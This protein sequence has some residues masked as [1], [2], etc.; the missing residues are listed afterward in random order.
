MIQRFNDDV[1][2]DDDGD[3]DDD[4]DD[5]DDNGSYDTHLVTAD[6]EK[7]KTIP[8]TNPLHYFTTERQTHYEETI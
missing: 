4:D 7:Y 6:V 3:D 1:D 5:N 8:Y 2:D